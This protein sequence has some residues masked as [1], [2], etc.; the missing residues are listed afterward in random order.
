MN[1][2]IYRQKNII[3]SG[4]FP[5]LFAAG[6]S[7]NYKRQIGLGAALECGREKKKEKPCKSHHPPKRLDSPC[8]Q[9]INGRFGPPPTLAK[10]TVNGHEGV[11]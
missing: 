8:E 5:S 1:A 2:R 9:S 4:R 6:I 10:G 3:D 11:N 7:P